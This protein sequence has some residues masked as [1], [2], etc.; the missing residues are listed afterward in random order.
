MVAQAVPPQTMSTDGKSKKAESPT[1]MVIEAIK[2]P[3]AEKMPITVA[4]SIGGSPRENEKQGPAPKT[5][6]AVHNSAISFCKFCAL[7]LKGHLPATTDL[8][9]DTKSGKLDRQLY[10]NMIKTGYNY[11]Q[12]SYGWRTCV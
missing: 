12:F 8:A 10:H 6:D 2:R 11:I 5:A 1:F 4:I 3:M 7:L 9:Q